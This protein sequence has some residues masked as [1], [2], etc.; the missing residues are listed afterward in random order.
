MLKKL[1]IGALAVALAVQS[2]GCILSRIVDR[3]FVGFGG[4][5]RNKDRIL[6]GLFLL[7]PSAA[8]DLVGL[9][10][11]ILLLVIAGDD[12]GSPAPVAND[13]RSGDQVKIDKTSSQLERLDAPDREK[14]LT[15]AKAAFEGGAREFVLGR[16][17]AGEWIEVPVS[18]EK[19]RELKARAE[20][21]EPA[22]AHHSVAVGAAPLGAY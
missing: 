5:P 1:L 4:P 12:F 22:A 13:S 9:P 8:I 2:T 15:A 3:A 7:V 16:T 11:E 21:I 19:L 10:L 18:P 20:A 14:A 17:K 6:T